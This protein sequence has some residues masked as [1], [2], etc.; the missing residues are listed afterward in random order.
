MTSIDKAIFLP[1]NLMVKTGRAVMPCSLQNHMP[2]QNVHLVEFLNSLLVNLLL[3]LERTKA[4]LNKLLQSYILPNLTDRPKQGFGLPVMQFLR[5]SSIRT[6]AES[7]LDPKK[8]EQQGFLNSN[9][10][11]KR[12]DSMQTHGTD[13]STSIWLVLMFQSWFD[14]SN[15]SFDR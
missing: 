4:P 1:N 6:W 5:S 3:N 7:L 13:W 11:S 10:I 9:V 2:I 14:E 8:T 15:C 12:W